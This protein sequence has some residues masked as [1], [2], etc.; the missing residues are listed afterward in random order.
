MSR[1][2]T[3][4]VV[5]LA[6]AAAGTLCVLAARFERRMAIAQEDMAVF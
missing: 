3:A 6:L 5:A 2:A 1:V 4:V